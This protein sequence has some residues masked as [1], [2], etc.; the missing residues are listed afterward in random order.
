M[1]ETGIIDAV[2]GIN[3]ARVT[4]EG[5]FLHRIVGADGFSEVVVTSNQAQAS[6]PGIVIKSADLA[7]IKSLLFCLNQL[8]SLALFDGQS[9][10]E[11]CSLAPASAAPSSGGGPI[12]IDLDTASGPQTYTLTASPTDG[13]A[14]QVKDA[15]GHA[16]VNPI[17]VTANGVILLDGATT[18]RINQNFASLNFR[19][20]ATFGKWLIF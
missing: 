10:E 16:T 1:P 8:L 12:P 19:W 13:V 18:A 9:A 15:T 3:G 14:Y 5:A 6:D 20:N 4:H 17:T 11:L 2:D 7:D